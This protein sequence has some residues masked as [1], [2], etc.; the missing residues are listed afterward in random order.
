MEILKHLVDFILHLDKH[1]GDIIQD[2]GAW[3]YAI[4]FA[5]IFFETGVVVLPFL[6]A[7]RCYLRPVP[8][9]HCPVRP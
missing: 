8:W 4:L 9:R 7:T 6:P 3:T 2:Y 5:I 1:L